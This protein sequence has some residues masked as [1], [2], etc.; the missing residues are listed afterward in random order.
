MGNNE[1]NN[2]ERQTLEEVCKQMER[3]FASLGV[4]SLYHKNKIAH[5][6]LERK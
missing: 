6:Q 5:T 2:Q 3:E 1:I 4:K